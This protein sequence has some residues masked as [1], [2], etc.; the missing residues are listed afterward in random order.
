MKDRI[1]KYLSLILL[2][3]LSSCKI[4][5]LE[6]GP[7]RQLSVRVFEWIGVELFDDDEQF[8]LK[9]VHL[10]GSGLLNHDVLVAG[11]VEE[12]GAFGTFII[13]SDE[14]VRMLVDLSRLGGVPSKVAKG[15]TMRIIGKVQSGEKGHFYL[16]ANAVNRG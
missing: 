11:K 6:H 16:V 3:S 5:L 1:I 2:I 15:D 12:V 10:D 4:S 14:R 7:V 9:D 13:I 8:S